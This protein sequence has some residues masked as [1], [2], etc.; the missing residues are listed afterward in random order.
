MYSKKSTA[1]MSSTTPSVTIRKPMAGPAP[2]RDEGNRM[3]PLGSSERDS[4][5]TGDARNL[6]T[7]ADVLDF[8]LDRQSGTVRAIRLPSP[9]VGPSPIQGGEPALAM[10]A[11]MITDDNLEL[12]HSS[13]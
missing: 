2:A 5:V 11:A 13:A 8:T 6:V 9:G 10:S 3:I 4:A 7:L 1:T 12:S